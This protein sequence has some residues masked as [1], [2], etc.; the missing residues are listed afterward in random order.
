MW[1]SSLTWEESILLLFH[2]CI[3]L[4]MLTMGRFPTVACLLFPV[5][6]F[7]FISGKTGGGEN[8]R[9]KPAFLPA[10]PYKNK[11]IKMSREGKKNEFSCIKALWC[12]LGGKE[13][14]EHSFIFNLHEVMLWKL[15]KQWAAFLCS[16][17]GVFLLPQGDLSCPPCS[18]LGSFDGNLP[19]AEPAGVRPRGLSVLPRGC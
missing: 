1:S 9:F 18:A 4:N 17:A 6:A 7:L 2:W 11:E 13:E 3:L 12:M 16:S 14:D 15:A 8:W 5:R 19:T 10:P